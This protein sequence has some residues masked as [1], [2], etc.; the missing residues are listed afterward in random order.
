[1]QEVKYQVNHILQ[2]TYTSKMGKTQE[3]KKIYDKNEPFVPYV[4]NAERMTE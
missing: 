1:M 3:K 4:N 2:M